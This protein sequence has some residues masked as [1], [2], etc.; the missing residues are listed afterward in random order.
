MKLTLQQQADKLGVTRQA[1]WQKTPKGRVY[2]RAYRKSEKYKAYNRA[3][4][5]K[6][7]H[8]ALKT[9]QKEREENI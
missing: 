1:V 9:K 7:Y 5:K 4:R 6:V 3:Y 2:R 8:L